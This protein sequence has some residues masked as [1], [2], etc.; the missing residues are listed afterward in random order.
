MQGEKRKR[1]RARPATLPSTMIS[2]YLKPDEKRA[3]TYLALDMQT[4]IAAMA[5]EALFAKYGSQITAYANR[6]AASALE[7]NDGNS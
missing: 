2:I 1:S 4:S 3:L 5:R 7:A 6:I